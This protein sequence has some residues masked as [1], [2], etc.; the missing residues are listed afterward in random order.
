MAVLRRLLKHSLFSE[1]HFLN[2]QSLF[3]L[4]LLISRGKK[5]EKLD[6]LIKIVDSNGDGQ[7][8]TN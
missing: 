7:I 8:A 3:S 4:G 1:G 5:I 2:T 6:Q